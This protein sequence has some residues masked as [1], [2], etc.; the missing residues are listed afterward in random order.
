MPIEP[1]PERVPPAG[2]IARIGWLL[3]GLFC[4]GLGLIGVIVP[5]MPTTIFLILAAACFARSS[6]RL[7]RWLLDHPRF[8]PSIRVWQSEGAI[9]RRGKWAACI[10]IT[11]GYVLFLIGAHPGW[12]TA[13]VVA[14]LMAGCATWIFSRP[15]PTGER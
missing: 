6:T 2:R 15:L 11:L 3:L 7:E 12:I 1:P 5:L 9:P 8:G 14:L 4:V 13:G 10:G